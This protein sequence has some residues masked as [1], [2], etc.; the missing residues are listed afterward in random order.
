MPIAPPEPEP[1]ETAEVGGLIAHA[2][3]GERDAA[4]QRPLVPLL[5]TLLWLKRSLLE[6]RISLA[7]LKRILFGK[8]TEK[9]ARK[10]QDPPN[11]GTQHPCDP[12]GDGQNGSP[13][14]AHTGEPPGTDTD[15][16]TATPPRRGHGR[17]GGA[18]YPGAERRSCPQEPLAPG[19]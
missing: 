19:L 6:T 11:A 10:R 13:S 1:I 9:S 16:Q 8:R 5:R 18:D 3:P 12:G 15:T 14:D 17:R 7:K 4:S 2:E